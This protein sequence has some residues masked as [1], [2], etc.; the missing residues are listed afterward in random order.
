MGKVR[1]FLH[2]IGPSGDNPAGP[3]I[4]ASLLVVAAGIVGPPVWLMLSTF[5]GGGSDCGL[6]DA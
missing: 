6:G 3:F 4:A 2:S 5:F 1:R